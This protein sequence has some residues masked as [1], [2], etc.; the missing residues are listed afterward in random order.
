MI[1]LFKELNTMNSRKGSKISIILAGRQNRLL[2]AETRLF[3]EY[4]C[5]GGFYLILSLML[6]DC[7][8][9]MRRC[10]SQGEQGGGNCPSQQIR[11]NQSLCPS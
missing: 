2:A 4:N 5:K 9:N 8:R 10:M 11:V 7:Y 1:Y 6:T 3:L